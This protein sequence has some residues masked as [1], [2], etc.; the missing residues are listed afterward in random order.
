MNTLDLWRNAWPAAL[1]A[2]SPFTKLSE[3]RWCFDEADEQR[4]NLSGS[5]AMIRL[6]DHAV[7]ISVRQIETLGLQSFGREILAHEIGHHVYAPG[8]L[9]DH[10]RLQAR[11]RRSLPSREMFA[12]T[13]ANIYTDLLI[14]DRLQRQAGLDMAGVYTR[15]R[16]AQDT[17][18]SALWTFYMRTY[19]LLWNLPRGSLADSALIDAV[20]IEAD[21]AARLVRV[22][23]HDWLR[24][25][26]RFACL[27]LR[28][29]LDEEAPSLPVA[30]LDTATAGQGRDIPDGLTELDDDELDGDIHPAFDPEL[31]GLSVNL[32]EVDRDAPTGTGR[33]LVGG[34]QKNNYR[35]PA[36]FLALMESLG[37]EVDGREIV[38]RYYRERAL[39]HIV[40]F[41][42]RPAPQS[43][44]PHPEGL[45]VW[46]PGGALAAIDWVETVVKSPRI[47]PGITTVERLQGE[48]PGGEPARQPIQLYLGIDCSGSMGNPAF[49]VSYP[50]LAGAVMVLSALRA[51]ANVMVCLSGEPG[52][53]AETTGFIRDEKKLLNT[54]T[55]YLGTGYAFGIN[56]LEAQFMLQPPPTH[57]THA[58]VISDSDMFLMIRQT[59]NG[60]DIIHT[61]PKLCSAGAT[62][63]LQISEGRHSEDIQMLKAAGWNVH[64]VT[65]MSEVVGF[66]AAFSRTTW[67]KP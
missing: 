52:E 19:E 47:I 45:D 57:P 35:T 62:M 44:D 63:V 53:F 12:G 51:R 40:R 27:V 54:L 49:M 23:A 13:I 28:F 8:D 37:V 24:G 58:L 43:T 56:R 20:Q 38:S 15:L 31:T 10:A 25:A 26:G 3:P 39:P 67:G 22:Y 21:L 9:R 60:Q 42:S 36:E 29:L 7:V 5:F 17:P 32:D 66:A 34:K 30:W 50:V 6:K 18:S 41:P 16:S 14:N 33:E 2:W 4:E 59:P 11:M 61:I 48:G 55:S 46:E 65:S 64:C 1:Q